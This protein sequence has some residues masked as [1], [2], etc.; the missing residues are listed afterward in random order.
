M[1]EFIVVHGGVDMPPT[2][3]AIEVLRNAGQAGWRVRPAAIDAVVAALGV[4][5]SDPMFNAGF[6]SV[7]NHDGNVEVDAA[8]VDGHSGR[9]GAVAA[10]PDLRHPARVAA[11]VLQSG[12]AVLVSGDGARRL[13]DSLGEAIED[14]RTEDQVRV[15]RALQAGESLSPFT[16]AASVPNTETVGAVCTFGGTLVAGTSTGGVCGKAA[17]RIGD[18]AVFGA[19]HWA[20][21]RHAVLCSGE[22][23]AI[24]RT[25]L[26][27]RVGELMKSGVSVYEAVEWG[28]R[29]VRRETGAICAILGV[30]AAEGVVAA[31]YS[32][33]AFPVVV[34]RNDS[35]TVIDAKH[36]GEFS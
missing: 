11:A 28:V 21:E 35:S 17:G 10:V 6:G 3:S 4:L 23:E 15:W 12:A 19:G 13:A 33:F 16:G 36:V 27:F 9:V 2:D 14:L 26:A 31:A 22:G 30:D 25:H 24:I 20:D 32:G 7:L 1:E 18:S 8:I 29:L 5:E 34:Q